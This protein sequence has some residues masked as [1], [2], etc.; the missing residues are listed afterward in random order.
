MFHPDPII[1]AGAGPCGST[2]ALYLARQ[3][4]PVL[5]LE[6]CPALPRDQRASTFHPPTL[7]MLDDLGV[8]LDSSNQGTGFISLKR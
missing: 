5:L 4:I 3:D 1:I 7:E 2:L 6:R 8:A